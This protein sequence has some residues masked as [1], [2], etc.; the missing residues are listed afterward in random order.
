MKQSIVRSLLLSAATFAIAP[1]G[2]AQT[3]PAA[4]DAGLQD[5]IVTATK[6]ATPLQD[7][8]IAV[9]AI[10]AEA[11]QN[12]GASDIRQ[13]NQLT[14]SLLVS[15]TSSEAGGGVAR[16]RGVGTVGDNPG[17]ESSVT[18]FIDG[19]YRSRTGAGLTELGNIERIEVLRGPQGTLF[20]KNTSAGLI[21][22]V[23][24][25]PKLGEFSGY[26]NASYG[27]FNYINFGAGLN[28]PLGDKVAVTID[29]SYS[30]R[31]GFLT[32][33]VSGRDLN[34]RDR[35][36][37]RGQLGFEP[38]DD[39]KIRLIADYAQRREECCGA[40]YL[41]S[42]NL[43]AAGVSANSVAGLIRSIP[44]AA[45]GLGIVID[46]PKL[47][48]TAITPG[49]SFRSNVDDWGLSAEVNWD[50]G[51]VKFA[52]ITGYRNWK[53]DRGQDADVVSSLDIL[54]REGWKQQFKTF[55]QE[56]RFQ[57][58]VGIVDWLVGGYYANEKL[59]L[60]DNLK[61][62]NDYQRFSN[63]LVAAN[64]LVINASVLNP[65]NS[66]CVNAPVANAIATSTNPAV[67]ASA[68]G[69]AGFLAGG[70]YSAALNGAGITADSYK[71]NSQNWAVFT[72]NVINFSDRFNISLGARYTEE[73]KSLDAS[74]VSNNPVCLAFTATAALRSLAT[75]PCVINSNLDQSFTGE[76]SK[77]SQ[78]T[79]TAVASYKLTDDL[80]TYFSFSRGYKAG[81]FNLDRAGTPVA[82]NAVSGAGTAVLNNVPQSIN[83]IAG[84]SYS[85]YTSGPLAGFATAVPITDIASGA[86]RLATSAE[87]RAALRFEPEKVD[88]FEIGAKFGTSTLSI[89]MAAYYQKIKDFQLNTFNGISFIVENLRNVTARGVE[90][91]VTAR[92]TDNLTL[93]GGTA[94]GNT[95]YDTNSTGFGKPLSDVLYQL[96]GQTISNAPKYVVN[97]SANYSFDVGQS[98]LGAFLY[99]D[100]RYQSEINSGS[101]LDQEKKQ[102]GVF[103]MNARL[104]LN[105][106][107][108]AWS[109]ELWA[110]NLLDTTYQQVAF[111]APLQGGGSVAAVQN[112]SASVANQLFGTFL[113]EPRTFG[114]T[115]RYKF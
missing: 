96:P 99:G 43:T 69:T 73:R 38:T 53:L 42:R 28:A 41:P 92:P 112:G 2:F 46:D 74:L 13:L 77:E 94:L 30:K 14:P 80:M 90:L 86:A 67:P 25:A 109:V 29:G 55:S 36:L 75:L 106:A 111:D 1:Y 62:G 82:V 52:S 48:Q 16:I 6:R 65:G 79:G 76:K 50:L 32:D 114:V 23:T 45:G 113:A 34:N 104:G 27:N 26:G 88:A 64:L 101:D 54:R 44:T 108:K 93:V 58:D 68:R 24:K 83:R 11:L 57:G 15:S 89:N 8:P 63:C 35:W 5:I 61:Y 47:R 91:E 115:A 18:V 31:D 107:D 17:L 66:S 59:T 78:W 39:I 98:G 60:T 71:Q 37:V 85:V 105:G 56:L 100:F 70:G 103:V 7:V 10:G 87:R 72:H 19:V 84:Q 40:V 12:S 49:Q 21:N 51:A 95:K 33:V 81:G 110:Q 4:A 97:G 22:V 3:A 20:G 102:G 9:S